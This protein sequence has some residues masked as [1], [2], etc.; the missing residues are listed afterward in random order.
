MWPMFVPGPAPTVSKKA[1]WNRYSA[2]ASF[3]SAAWSQSIGGLN[4]YDLVIY[5]N[6]S[7]ANTSVHPSQLTLVLNEY[8]SGGVYYTVGYY[9]VPS[10]GGVTLTGT[11]PGTGAQNSVDVVCGLGL[12]LTY[13]GAGSVC[14]ALATTTLNIT[15]VDNTLIDSTIITCAA[16]DALAGISFST[17]QRMSSNASSSYSVSTNISYSAGGTSST[18]T[19]TAAA[20][21]DLIGIQLAFN[22][23]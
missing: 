18:I 14:T 7:T 13:V 20:S 15:G 10:G 3:Y 8:L 6:I 5:T 9:I 19:A 21:A 11:A 1:Y 12:P 4:Q 22:I 16:D 2:P 23:L 17:G